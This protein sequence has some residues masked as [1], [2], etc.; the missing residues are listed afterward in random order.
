MQ[1][2]LHICAPLV[3]INIFLKSSH[4]N[5]LQQLSN[6]AREHFLMPPIIYVEFIG[7]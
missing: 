7:N 4:K 1:F 5:L 2:V 6:F 3:Y